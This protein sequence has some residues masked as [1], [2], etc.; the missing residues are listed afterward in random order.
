MNVS[1]DW[2]WNRREMLDKES[3]ASGLKEGDER[4]VEVEIIRDVPLLILTR[5]ARS[6]PC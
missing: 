6:Q 4:Y 3:R 2:I 1:G 5:H